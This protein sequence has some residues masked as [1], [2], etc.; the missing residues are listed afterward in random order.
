MK[1]IIKSYQEFMKTHT[2]Y[3]RSPHFNMDRHGFTCIYEG[4]VDIVDG[5][6]LRSREMVQDL[7]DAFGEDYYSEYVYY[8]TVDGWRLPYIYIF[9][10]SSSRKV[11]Y[12][13]N[14]PTHKG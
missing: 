1:P 3:S 11:S 7:V 4:D 13:T 2:A 10:K 6:G 5:K 14:T 9:V 12:G 8:R